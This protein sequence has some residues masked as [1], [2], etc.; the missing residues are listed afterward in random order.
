MSDTMTTVEK[1]EEIADETSKE[2]YSKLRDHYNVQDVIV[3][4]FLHNMVH[5]NVTIALEKLIG[6]ENE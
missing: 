1:I 3:P 2:I 5:E 4:T 6:D